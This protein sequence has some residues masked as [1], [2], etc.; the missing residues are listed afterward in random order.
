ME[1]FELIGSSAPRPADGRDASARM[2]NKKVIS[3]RYGS[4][5]GSG[6][7]ELYPS[8]TPFISHKTSE[9]TDKKNRRNGEKKKAGFMQSGSN[10]IL[11]MKKEWQPEPH[12]RT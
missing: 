10:A 12:T 7:A 5:C 11:E 8:H 9:K 3:S 6:S 1:I 2:Q 4:E